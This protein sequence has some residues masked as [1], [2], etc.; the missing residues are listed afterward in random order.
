MRASI[1]RRDHYE[2]QE[3]RR[4]MREGQTRKIN[5]AHL[6]HHIVP[7]DVDPTLGLDP[8]NLISL[9]DGCHNAIHGRDKIAEFSA[10]I[11]R[12]KRATEEKW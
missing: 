3:C 10:P 9:C 8:D 2:C 5:R 11:Q 1:L 7:Y 6:V 12:K 4:K